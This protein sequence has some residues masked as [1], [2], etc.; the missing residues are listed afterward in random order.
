M[1]M[2]EM[3]K[4]V[5]EYVHRMKEI[6]RLEKLIYCKTCEFYKWTYDDGELCTNRDC[7]ICQDPFYSCHKSPSEFYVNESMNIS[8]GNSNN[9]CIFYRRKSNVNTTVSYVIYHFNKVT[10]SIK[11]WKSKFSNSEVANAICGLLIMFGVVSGF[12][13]VLQSTVG[14]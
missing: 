7:I 4:K 6:N 12:I 8:V 2:V 14:N 3:E 11:Q 13:G 1:E 5:K 10:R 9:D